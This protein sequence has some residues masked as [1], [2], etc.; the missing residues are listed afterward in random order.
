M[1]RVVGFELN[2]QHP[3]KAVEFYSNVFSWEIDEAFFGYRPVR[4]DVRGQGMEGGIVEGPTDY[5]HGTRIQIEV[6][7]IEESIRK[8]QEHGALIVRDKMEFD[9]FYLAYLVDPTG[10]GFG[11]IEKK[12]I[13]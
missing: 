10:L 4:T 2:S 12:K 1:G 5:P 13:K 8:A 3:E 6:N 11:L 9:D 7:S